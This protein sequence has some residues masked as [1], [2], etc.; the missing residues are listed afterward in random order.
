MR[1]PANCP[2]CQA[3]NAAGA[4]FCNQCGARMVRTAAPVPRAARRWSGTPLAW[5]SVVAA[6]L[7]WVGAIVAGAGDRAEPEDVSRIHQADLRVDSSGQKLIRC[8]LC[9]GT[10]AAPHFTRKDP[11]QPI[12]IANVSSDGQVTCPFCDGSGWEPEARDGRYVVVADGEP[13]AYSE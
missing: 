8:L 5:G 1:D 3:P 13:T 7:I 12:G 4:V 6:S 9:R 11:S 2:R 10:G